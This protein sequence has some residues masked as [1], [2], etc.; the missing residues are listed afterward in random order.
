MRSLRSHMSRARN[1]RDLRK[2]TRPAGAQ[3]EILEKS[4][5]QRMERVRL[6]RC[7]ATHGR[8]G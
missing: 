3:S 5:D 8:N 1:T 7:H 6:V 4:D 2:V